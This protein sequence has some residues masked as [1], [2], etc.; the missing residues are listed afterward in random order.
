MTEID[1]KMV[2]TKSFILNEIKHHKRRITSILLHII[3]D[4]LDIF[5]GN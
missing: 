2:K 4:R 3:H 5:S 1:F